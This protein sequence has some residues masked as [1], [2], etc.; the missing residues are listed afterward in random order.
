MD[1][2]ARWLPGTSDTNPDI[3]LLQSEAQHT[4]AM[5]SLNRRVTGT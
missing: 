3:L 4:R 5:S 2:F 1:F